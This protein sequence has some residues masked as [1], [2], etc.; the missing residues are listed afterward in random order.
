MIID[1]KRAG[2]NDENIR[3][4]DIFEDL[5]VNFAVAETA[6][7]GLAEGHFEVPAD[8]LGQR[9]V[10][11]PREDFETLVVHTVLTEVISRAMTVHEMK[12]V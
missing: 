1:G 9:G 10:G 7:Q 5:E 3:A 11:G 4:T 2:L 12:M 8:G 6:E